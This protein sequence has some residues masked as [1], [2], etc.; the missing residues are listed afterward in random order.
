MLYVSF[1]SPWQAMFLSFPGSSNCFKCFLGRC[2]GVTASP[3]RKKEG[4]SGHRRVFGAQKNG[5]NICKSVINH[6]ICETWGA[7]FENVIS[8]T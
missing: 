3:R 4:C 8:N 5:L 1:F 6:A 2:Q 7:G